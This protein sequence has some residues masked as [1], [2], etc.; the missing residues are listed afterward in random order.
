MVG[1][2]A[3]VCWPRDV[4]NASASGRKDFLEDVASGPS[5]PDCCD[6]VRIWS[7]FELYERVFG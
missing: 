6:L 7:F 2:V 3:G 1:P 5:N 4:V